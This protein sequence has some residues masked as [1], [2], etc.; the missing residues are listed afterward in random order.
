M[1]EVAAAPEGADAMTRRRAAA[2]AG[3]RGDRA[4]ARAYLHDDEPAVRAS[5]LRALERSGDLDAPLLAA[6]LEDPAPG[7]RVTALELA[8][9]RPD[10][11]VDAAAARLDDPDQR[12]VEAAAWTCGEKVSAA[13]PA[14]SAPVVAA[15]IR[16]A[17]SHADPLC[18]ESAIAALGAIAHPD[19]L[20]AVL[21]GLDDKPEIRRRAVIAL[22]PFDGPEVEAALARAG[23]DRDKQVRAAAA[24]L[25]GPQVGAT[26]AE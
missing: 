19:G 13:G 12:V 22:A 11:P 8:A 26:G 24:E 25:L 21:A 6:A 2:V 17:R 9:S 14:D 10:V 20:P 5:A 3:H 1:A 15:L 23:K 18:R 7:V 16:V 4:Q